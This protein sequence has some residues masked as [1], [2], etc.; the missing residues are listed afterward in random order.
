MTSLQIAR[1]FLADVQDA[2][3]NVDPAPTVTL[4]AT[5]ALGILGDG[6]TVLVL[7]PPRQTFET[8]NLTENELSL[9]AVASAEDPIEGWEELEEIVNTLRVPLAL[10]SAEM[11]MWQGPSGSPWPAALMK[12]TITTTD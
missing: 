3:S 1:D 8:Y 12:T 10:D 7:D 5:E 11:T 4:S 2:L 9:V 6:Q